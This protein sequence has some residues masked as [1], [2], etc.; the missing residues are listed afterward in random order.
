MRSKGEGREDRKTKTKIYFLV[1]TDGK[2]PLVWP[3]LESW[4]HDLLCESLTV[5]LT[6]IDPSVC[7]QSWE[8]DQRYTVRL[9]SETHENVQFRDK[10]PARLTMFWKTSSVMHG[11]LL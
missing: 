2:A 11:V 9:T 3:E 7:N 5:T 1:S 8:Y 4:M 6:L 10:Y